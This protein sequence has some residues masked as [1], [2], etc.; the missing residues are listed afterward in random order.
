[1]RARACVRAHTHTYTYSL[2][3]IST[4]LSVYLFHDLPGIAMASHIK[5]GARPVEGTKRIGV[6]VLFFF[7]F[8]LSSPC[9]ETDRDDRDRSLARS[10]NQAKQRALASTSSSFWK[11]FA[12]ATPSSLRSRTTC[13]ITRARW[14][15][16][17]AESMDSSPSPT[18]RVSRA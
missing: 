16:T 12:T 10:S 8:F 2:S 1:M 13:R 6:G 3:F 9:L 5:P 15:T 11:S 18:E 4:D 7:S 17:S 14:S